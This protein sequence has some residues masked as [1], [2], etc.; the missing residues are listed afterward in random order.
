MS[1][2]SAHGFHGRISLPNARR[3]LTRLEDV[4]P[5]FVEEPLLP[6]HAH[7]L[8]RLADC[9]AIPLATGE[10]LYSRRDF[11]EPLLAGVAVVQ[12]DLSHAGGIS[13]VRRIASLAEVYD[14]VLAPHCPLGRSPWRRA[15]RWRSPRQT[16]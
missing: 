9:S 7:L 11:L 4:S 13:E 10:R 15:C 6:E 12:P 3:I 16:S 14:A 2:R 5:L 1:S 8:A